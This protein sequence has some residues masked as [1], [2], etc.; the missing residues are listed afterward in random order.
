MIHIYVNVVV[1]S[2]V[3]IRVDDCGVYAF[4]WICAMSMVLWLC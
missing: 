4:V 2:V 1:F 3:E